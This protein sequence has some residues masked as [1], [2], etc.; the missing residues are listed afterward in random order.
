MIMKKMMFLLLFLP[1][2]S[3]ILFSQTF[4]DTVVTLQGVE[5]QG[6]RF[7]GLSSG[8][9]KRLQV[10]NNLSSVTGTAAEAF[11]QIPSLTTDMEGG[12]TFR[13]SNKA[14]ILW[15]GV[16][17]GLLEEYSGDVLI[18]LPAV[19]LNHIRAESYPSIDLMPD[20][21]A[22]LLN[23]SPSAPP[24]GSPLQL[25]LG[26]GWNE[27][28]NAGAALDLH[29]GA[30]RIAGKYNY[31]K[32]YRKRSFRRSTANSAGVT[33]MD[34]SASARPDVHTA[35]LLAS[36]DV[37]PDD[38]LSAY[39]L[40]Y[41]MD[42]SRYGAINNTRKNPAG[43]VVN[44]MLRNRYNDQRQE[45]AAAE[46][47]W[48]HRF[49]GPHD[50][51]EFVFNYNNFTYD[52]DNDYKN[53]NPQTGAIVA[54]DNLFITQQKDNYYLKGAYRKGFSGGLLFEAGY[55]GQIK[56]ERYTSDANN[57]VQDDWV[58]S[59]E[60]S[61]GYT[62]RRSVHLVYASLEK[63]WER[64]SGEIGVQGEYSRQRA[65]SA[66][67]GSFHP[68]PRARLV[69]RTNGKD[70]L[71]LAYLQRVIRPL[72]TDYNDF[73]NNSDAT[74]IIQGNPDLKNE[75]IHSLDLSYTLNL[76]RFRLSPGV[77]FR[78]KSNRI[79]EMVR[80]DMQDMTVWKKE[81]AGD[82]RIAGAELSASWSPSGYLSV[83]LSGNVF[84][85]EIDGR[86]LGYGVKKSM[87]CHDMK[88]AVNIHFTADTELQLDG[89]RISD[90][91]TP[92]GEI[93]SR[94]A[95]NAGFS[96]YFMQRKW[97]LNLSVNNI[98]DSLEETTLIDTPTLQMEQIRNRD[99]RVAWLTLTCRL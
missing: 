60:K 75:I 35:D 15:N 64:I 7:G 87:V 62:F 88:G 50:N 41:L 14:A 2:A 8:E 77:Y 24:G 27:R 68:Y 31:R 33:E 36:Y 83:S 46:V 47:R 23:L 51:L 18:Q 86:T 11:R 45:A 34:N 70:A 53:E 92:Q 16:P 6:V 25:T 84:R 48:Q 63:Q 1:G 93:K 71:S 57:L 3:Q 43:E 69:Y 5:I 73:V 26:G 94:Y 10:G 59:P 74:H 42:Y 97:R 29:P 54:Q 78:Y 56:A 39:G 67:H 58:H 13:G 82:S 90:Q 21:D 40:Y 85:D 95:V 96:Q 81:N 91:L 22:G 79:M 30:F 80:E 89:F 20:G 76:S 28:Y 61:D 38:L 9:V 98:F 17:Y 44:R 55:T 72:G 66:E 37:T 52:E 19:F 99:A 32:E 12:V 4:A 49:A 65:R